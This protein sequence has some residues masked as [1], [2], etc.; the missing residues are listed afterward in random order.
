MMDAN[1]VR[2]V[3]AARWRNNTITSQ[4]ECYGVTCQSWQSGADSL[5]NRVGSASK[6][7]HSTSTRALSPIFPCEVDAEISTR[8]QSPVQVGVKL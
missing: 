8:R 4:F 6:L 2:A 5:L 3:A 1:Q 7:H